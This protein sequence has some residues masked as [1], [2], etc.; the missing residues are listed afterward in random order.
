MK[1]FSTFKTAAIGATSLWLFLF[2]L[3]PFLLI[4]G[5][6]FLSRS[7]TRFLVPELSFDGYRIVFSASAFRILVESIRLAAVAALLCLAM[8]YPFAYFLSRL[9]SRHKTLLLLLMIIPF[10]TNSL[11]R[12]YALIFIVKTNGLLNAVLLGS[13]LIRK[14]ISLLYT[15]TAV[16]LGMV[17]TLL[18]FMIL[19]IYAAVEKLDGRLLEAAR[20]LGSGKVRSFLYITL[21]L[22]LPG[23]IAGF[24]LVFLPALGMFY[25]PDILGG[26]KSMLIGNF[27]KNQFL[28]ARDWPTGSAA[29]VILTLM[30]VFLMLAYHF[31]APTTEKKEGGTR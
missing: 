24:M 27:I 29:S 18:P 31:S 17:Y 20:D 25:I 9:T 15:N 2:A 3:L 23:I 4:F 28:T 6:S 16:L 19:P 26:A 10:W 30:M 7:E 5:A 11:I 8:G 13:G 14:P 21:P 1:P 12:T 22:T